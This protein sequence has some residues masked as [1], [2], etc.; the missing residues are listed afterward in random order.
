[1]SQADTKRSSKGNA[2][3]LRQAQHERGDARGTG[4]SAHPEP[5][6]G[7]AEGVLQVAAS[8]SRLTRAFIHLDRLT[9]NLRLLQELAGARQLWPVV[10]GDAYGHGAPS[11]AAHLVGLGYRTLGVADRTRK[12][13]SIPASMS[14]TASST[15]ATPSVW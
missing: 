6:E 12:V 10:K 14:A 7:G 4:P 1:M 3:M 15:S 5:V 13:A 11:V 9:H 8:A 2:L